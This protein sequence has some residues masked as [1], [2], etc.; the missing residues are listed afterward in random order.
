MGAFGERLGTLLVNSEDDDALGARGDR[1]LDL[2]V[3]VGQRD[4]VGKDVDDVGAQVLAGLLGATGDDA[5]KGIGRAGDADKI[6]GF[7]STGVLRRAD[8]AANRG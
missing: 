2:R 7:L 8:R 1:L 6:D 5:M 4:F 3:V